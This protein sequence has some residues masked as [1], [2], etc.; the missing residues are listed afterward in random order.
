YDELIISRNKI[1]DPGTTSPT[2]LVGDLNNDRT[3]NGLDWGIMAGVWFTA[4]PTADLNTDGIVNSID[5]SLL[6]QNWGKS[7]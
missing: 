4:D 6:N 2:T 7:I 5:F 1:A 3:V